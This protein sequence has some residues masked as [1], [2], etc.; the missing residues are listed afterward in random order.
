M[1]SRQRDGFD[2]E[3]KS[4]EQGFAKLLV[5]VV[6]RIP[7]CRGLNHEN[8]FEVLTLNPKPML[9]SGQYSP[10]RI[11]KAQTGALKLGVEDGQ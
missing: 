5:R 4:L 6:L 2:E 3:V 7:Q 8:C 9:F 1:C 10:I 11:I